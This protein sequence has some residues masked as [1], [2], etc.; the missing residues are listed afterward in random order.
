L[1]FFG[2]ISIFFKLFYLSPD[3]SNF[4][5]NIIK[6]LT[7]IS[8]GMA[9]KVA[10]GFTNMIRRTPLPEAMPMPGGP[11]SESTLEIFE[12]SLQNHIKII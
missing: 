12:M 9:S 6:P 10:F 11:F 1:R 7:A 8:T 2:K 4:F 5:A 3:V